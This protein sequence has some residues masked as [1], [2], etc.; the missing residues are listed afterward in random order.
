MGKCIGL[1]ESALLWLVHNC[2]NDVGE[3]HWTKTTEQIVNCKNECGDNLFLLEYE[4]KN[5]IIEEYVQTYQVKNE[6]LLAFIALREKESK[7]IIKKSV[8]E[9]E[10]IDYHCASFLSNV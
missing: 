9:Y 10:M 2:T 8:W 6:T 5:G 7:K 1:N 4:S 3:L